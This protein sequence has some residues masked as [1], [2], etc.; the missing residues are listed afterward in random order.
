MKP[1]A[2]STLSPTAA[3]AAATA[4]PNINMATVGVKISPPNIQEIMLKLVG[5]EPLVINRFSMKAMDDIAKKQMLG[6]TPKANKKREPKDFEELFINAQYRSR[7]GWLG[8]HA[9]CIRNAMISACRIVDFK[10]TLGKL[11]IFVVAD[12]YDALDETPLLRIYG[13]KPH[14]WLAPVQQ[15]MTID[16]RPRP[17]WEA[18]QW[19]LRPRIR[20][21][22]DQF[23]ITDV[24]NLIMRVGA[25]VGIGEG[26]PDSKHSA[27]LGF[28]LFDV[29]SM[30]EGK[31]AA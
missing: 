4:N 24:T 15:N 19:E 20:Y 27:G 2:K 18:G 11:S 25:Q 23:S 14:N 9:S 21:D 10:M 6:S 17:R 29:A 31:K 8:V 28:G 12:G 16:L 13:G 30:E 3:A 22:A 7:D 1:K 26:R 5:T